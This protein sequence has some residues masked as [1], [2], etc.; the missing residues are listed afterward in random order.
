MGKR[1]LWLVHDVMTH[2]I[3]LSEAQIA[4]KL[5]PVYLELNNRYHSLVIYQKDLDAFLMTVK[6][7]YPCECKV[8]EF[9][10][11][12]MLLGEHYIDPLGGVSVFVPWANIDT[13]SSCRSEEY[14]YFFFAEFYATFKVTE[15]ILYNYLHKSRCRFAVLDCVRTDPAFYT[16]D[17]YYASKLKV[18]MHY[19]DVLLVMGFLFKMLVEN[20]KLEDEGS[21][22]IIYGQFDNARLRVFD[23]WCITNIWTLGHDGSFG[24]EMPLFC[25]WEFDQA[26]RK[27][28]GT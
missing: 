17:K 15:R 25:Q 14:D 18:Q 13:V 28:V 24:H 22:S 21:M 7:L 9:S 4:N 26:I 11:G 10:E 12:E 19:A 3:E 27:S 5:H 8:Y 16:N 2:D 1:Y 23:R 20:H 6:A